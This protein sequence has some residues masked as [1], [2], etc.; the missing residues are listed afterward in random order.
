MAYY[1]PIVA[2]TL[3]RDLERPYSYSTPPTKPI[4]AAGEI[5]HSVGVDGIILGYTTAY[6]IRQR[7]GAAYDVYDINGFSYEMKYDEQGIS[8]IFLASD[9]DRRIFSVRMWKEFEP[10]ARLTSQLSSGIRPHMVLEDVFVAERREET[11]IKCYDDTYFVDYGFCRYHFTP[12]EYQ[13]IEYSLI[14]SITLIGRR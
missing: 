7:Y 3:R 13:D 4:P 1:K 5:L 12:D 9:L 8:C 10:F 11:P 14:E 6:E 2:N